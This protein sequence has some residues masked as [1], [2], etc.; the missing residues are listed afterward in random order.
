MQR[1][2]RRFPGVLLALLCASQAFAGPAYKELDPRR[3]EAIS[4]ML[5]AEPAGFGQ[6]CSDRAA[7]E[8]IGARKVLGGVVAQAEGLLQKEF[9]KWDDA[10]YLDFSKTGRRPPGEAMLRAR[11][12]WLYPLV[13]AECLENRG[14]FLDR[15]NMVLD[16]YAGERTWTLP[17][18]D[19]DLKCFN[20]Q[21]YQVELA[22]ADFANDLAQTLYLLGNGIKPQ[23]R[24]RVMDALEQRIFAPVRASVTT[25]K[26]NWWLTAKMNWNAV[27]LR[28]VTGAALSVLPD[29]DDRA[30]FAAI[31]EHYSQYYMQGY[32]EDGYCTEGAGYWDFGFSN[33]IMLREQLLQSTGWKIDLFAN[34]KVRNVALF[35]VRIVLEDGGAPPFGDCHFGAKPD[36][37]IISYC[38]RVLGLGLKGFNTPNVRAGVAARC[39]NIFPNSATQARPAAAQSSDVGLRTYFDK[40]GVLICRPAPGS[41]C[42]LGV[43]IKGGGNTTHSHDDVGSF[44]IALG[45]EQPV[46]DPG[47]PSFYERG[48]FGPKRH[49]YKLINSFG[50]PVPLIA[51][52]LQVDATKIHPKIL[53]TH[54]T[55]SEDLI[56]IDLTTAY[57]VPELKQLV[58]TMR[59]NRQGAGSVTIEDRYVFSSPQTFELGLPTHGTFKQVGSDTIAFTSGSQTLRAQIQTPDGFDLT[60]EV[61]QENAPPFTRVGIRLK[62]PVTSGAVTVV[63]R[64]ATANA[65]P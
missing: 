7:W 56:R 2:C 21:A 65:T 5:R 49:T 57:A 55:D 60:S 40:A 10:A 50:H 41:A 62:K 45:D 27:C 6:P 26:G 9:P 28:G 42:R 22:S 12:E 43:G 54:F 17:A 48:T 63:F 31:G 52:Q 51:G 11:H 24:K 53:G 30:L 36:A 59:F 39:M 47:G 33:Y 58:R 34:P 3:I 29:R 46:G 37:G 16:E 20:R 18:H 64:P 1:I 13:M 32:G 4:A 15:I 23:T 44:A 25:G 35:G 38:N 61:I 8:S 19:A 14:R